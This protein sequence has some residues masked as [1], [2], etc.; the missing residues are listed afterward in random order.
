MKPSTVIKSFNVFNNNYFS[1]LP[2]FEFSAVDYIF[3]QG[4][5]ERLH[6]GVV[7][8]I[9][10]ATHALLD[11]VFTQFILIRIGSIS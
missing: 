7:I 11:I 8:A 1:L 6:T 5:E 10:F 4:G 9:T 2:G 3:F